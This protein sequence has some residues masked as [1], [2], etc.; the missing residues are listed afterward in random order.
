MGE[1]RDL[2]KTPPDGIRYME[3]DD[4]TVSSIYAEINGPGERCLCVH[5]VYL[6]MYICI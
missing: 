2:V 6:Y 5:Y 3:G 4:D 1:I